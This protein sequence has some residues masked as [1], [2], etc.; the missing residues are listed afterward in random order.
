MRQYSRVKSGSSLPFSGLRVKPASEES[1]KTLRVAIV[2]GSAVRVRRNVGFENCRRRLPPTCRGDL[3]LYSSAS[4]WEASSF[5]PCFGDN[6]PRQA[7]I[8]GT[9]P[10]EICGMRQILVEQALQGNRV[11]LISCANSRGHSTCPSVQKKLTS[12]GSKSTF[13]FIATWLVDGGTRSRWAVP[14]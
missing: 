9:E 8:R 6:F 4:G 14:R 5:S 11:S 1:R 12:G 13:A 3:V 10:G 7:V 2:S